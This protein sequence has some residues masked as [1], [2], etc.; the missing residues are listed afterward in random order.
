MKKICVLAVVILLILSISIPQAVMAAEN[1]AEYE[2]SIGYQLV[3]NAGL[4]DLG[5]GEVLSRDK[6]VSR[7]EF[8]QVIVNCIGYCT[9]SD[10]M[11]WSDTYFSTDENRLLTENSDKYSVFEDIPSTHSAYDATKTLKSLGIMN[12]VSDTA[13]GVDEHI[14]AIDAVTVLLR[15]G[16]YQIKADVDGGYPNGYMT[17]ANRLKLFSGIELSDMNDSVTGEMLA[18][19]IYNYLDV[20]VLQLTSIG[21][22]NDY[23]TDKDVTFGT[24]ILNL[25]KFEGVM[26]GNDMTRLDSVYCYPENYVSIDSTE[27]ILGGAV[28]DAWRLIGR[29]TEGRYRKDGNKR[30]IIYIG[31]ENNDRSVTIS[32][33]D[34]LD[35]SV[36]SNSV[37]I[38]YEQKESSKSISIPKNLPLIYNGVYADTYDMDVFDIEYGDITLSKNNGDNVCVIIWE[39]D[40]YIVSGVNDETIVADVDEY[41]VKEFDVNANDGVKIIYTEN[42]DDAK[43]EVNDILTV[44]ETETTKVVYVTKSDSARSVSIDSV[45]E[46]DYVV[47]NSGDTS[48]KLSPAF[49][50][51]QQYKRLKSKSDVKAYFD[52]FGNIA[53][54]TAGRESTYKLGYLISFKLNRGVWDY[55]VISK[56][57]SFDE[58]DV[59]DLTFAEKTNV[60]DE[61]NTTKTYKGSELEAKLKKS[62]VQY[63]LNDDGEVN[64]IEF[65][66]SKKGEEGRLYSFGTERFSRSVRDDGFS[67]GEF[68]ISSSTKILSRPDEETDYDG[69]FTMLGSSKS[70]HEMVMSGYS[71]NPNSFVA[72]VIVSQNLTTS[73]GYSNICAVTRVYETTSADGELIKVVEGANMNGAA[74]RFES[75]YD[76]TDKNGKK[77]TLFDIVEGN[78]DRNDSGELNTYSLG[79]G[80]IVFISAKSD[81]DREATGALL[82]W[83]ADMQNPY[84]SDGMQGYMP[85]KTEKLFV[86]SELVD[87][88]NNINRMY[89]PDALAP[90]KGTQITLNGGNP[91]SNLDENY[92]HSNYYDQIQ[93]YSANTDRIVYGYV[94]NKESDIL[95]VTSCDITQQKYDPS[96]IPQ[97][98]A[99]REDKT[100]NGIDYSG[101]YV[102]NLIKTSSFNGYGRI[103]INIYRDY[104]EAKVLSSDDARPYSQYGDRCSRVMCMTSSAFPRFL[105]IINDYRR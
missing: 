48:Y 86:R 88:D 70:R 81:K 90:F 100:V 68:I 66:L 22:Y 1:P 98:P 82:Y 7:G 34:F 42:T 79:R 4:Y 51:S 73:L 26:D 43:T 31:L 9:N 97:N 102:T 76:Y 59:V 36:K 14:G 91:Y 55:N 60:N 58:D 87:Y 74:V 38:T 80:D 18:T 92:T 104:A 27:Y 95:E 2:K 72:E 44:A 3:V 29:Y 103:T 20:P 6:T 24:E 54:M 37:N 28:S 78:F 71:T 53:W 89:D 67:N 94:L 57:Y 19:I 45:Y 41:D 47:I 33:E 10:S 62:V 65:P 85:G 64:Y 40:T 5:N 23:T 46:N 83:D 56:I 8:A 69:Y 77:C 84:N 13:F 105:V 25:H 35:Y 49:A 61:N 32:Y 93:N 50:K 96:G 11:I 101:V 52:M 15:I 17:N 39:Y 21:E 63:G 12:G 99:D 16:G 30:E 75:G